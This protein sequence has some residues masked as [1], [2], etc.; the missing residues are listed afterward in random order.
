MGK[1]VF[2]LA[3]TL[4]CSQNFHANAQSI[5]RNGVIET[6]TASI[7]RNGLD[8]SSSEKA[9]FSISAGTVI[10]SNTI[11]GLKAVLVRSADSIY[12]YGNMTAVSVSSGDILKTG[13]KIGELSRTGNEKYL[14]HFEIWK[15]TSNERPLL[16]SYFDTKKVL[17]LN[18]PN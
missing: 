7:P 9:V 5:V 14:L 15:G 6:A 11:E 2:I 17:N 3:A 10:S 16:L 8:I 1:K 18:G 12:V 13:Q 4:F